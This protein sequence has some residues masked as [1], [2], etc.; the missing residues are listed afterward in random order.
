MAVDILM[1]ARMASIER[2]LMADFTVH[3][4]PP[5]DARNAFL[6]VMADRIRGVVTYSGGGLV[7][8]ALLDALPKVE[9]IANMGVGHES[10]DLGAAHARNIVVTNAGSV[11]AVDVAEHAFGL[12]L[13]VGRAISFGDRHVRTGAWISQGRI[14]PTRRVT[15]RKLGIVGLGHIG[16]EIAKRAA[17][18]DMPVSYHNR[19]AR[20]DVPYRYVDDVVKLARE[21][22]VL[23]A[24]TPGGAAT[25]HLING[26]VLDALGA[27]GIF[28]NVGRGSVA[29]ETALVNALT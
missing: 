15:G 27:E 4:L 11:N 10:V 25:R 19:N 22:D 23:V 29:D 2:G 6:K 14:K 26:A 8:Q 18:F 20:T 7:D 17:A 5:P 16:L 1:I 28:I 3:H 12:I 13:D 24:A 9:I 21:V